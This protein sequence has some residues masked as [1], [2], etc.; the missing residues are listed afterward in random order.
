MNLTVK[1]FWNL[2]GIRDWRDWFS[3]SQSSRVKEWQAFTVA[4][5]GCTWGKPQS[6]RSNVKFTG[7]SFYKVARY[8]ICREW[9]KDYE[10]S[11]APTRFRPIK[12][13]WLISVSRDCVQ[14]LSGSIQRA[15]CLGLTRST[16]L[17]EHVPP[18]RVIRRTRVHI[19]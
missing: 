7:V 5:W 17:H 18:Q 19:A 6:E 2:N 8:R 10:L 11:Q 12:A 9:R 16:I 4:N 3:W 14:V 15:V 1:K 13:G